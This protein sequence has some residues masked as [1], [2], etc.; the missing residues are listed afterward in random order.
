MLLQEQKMMGDGRGRECIAV[1]DPHSC[2]GGRRL[3]VEGG[4]GGQDEAVHFDSTSTCMMCVPHSPIR[5]WDRDTRE[6]ESRTVN[7]EH[8]YWKNDQ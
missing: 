5:V 7:K 2:D 4:G 1:A 3:G 8:K 6:V